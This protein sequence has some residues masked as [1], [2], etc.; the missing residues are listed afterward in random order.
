MKLRILKDLIGKAKASKAVGSSSCSFIFVV[1]DHALRV[2][3]SCMKLLNLMEEGIINTEKLELRRKGF[4][5]LHAIYFVAP[6]EENFRRI[7]K[8]FEEEAKPM[9]GVVHIFSTNAVDKSLMGILSNTKPLIQRLGTFV[10]MN[11]DLVCNEEKTFQ[12]GM[13]P[14]VP[15]LYSSFNSSQTMAICIADRLATI[16]PTFMEFHNIQIIWNKNQNMISATIA[17]RLASRLEGFVA[18]S[19][20]PSAP[21]T[22]FI[23]LDR[24]ADILTP[25]MHDYFYQGMLYDL[26]EVNGQIVDYP[27]EDEKGNKMT[28]K[29][30]LSEEDSIWV[31]YR[32][33][34]IAEVMTGVSDQFNDF[35]KNNSTSKLQRGELDNLNLS[36]MSEI[37]KTMPQYNEI[38]NRYTLHMFLIDKLF[39]EFNKQELIEIGE[40]EQSMSTGI[41]DKGASIVPSKLLPKMLSK[42]ASLGKM[43]GV[44]ARLRLAMIA[45]LCMPMSDSERKSLFEMVDIDDRMTIQKLKW[46]GFNIERKEKVQV[47]SRKFQASQAK[48]KLK[49]VSYS[50]CRSTPILETI[51]KH[52]QQTPNIDMN[53]FDLKNIP[54]GST[55]IQAKKTG[56]SSL[57]LKSSSSLNDPPRLVVFMVGGITYPELRLLRDLEKTDQIGGFDM[58]CGGTSLL[59]PA[60]FLEGVRKLANPI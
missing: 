51:V 10:E 41:D 50:L 23:I 47:A 27:A 53:T 7:A 11:L 40:F 52:V 38:L 33:R 29:A 60:D 35:L 34:H 3:S 12:L 44:N 39:E 59:R 46:F 31:E 15:E 14:C 18:K 45:C 24:S 20:S 30:V 48:N 37:I 36:S 19:G 17:N 21:P 22:R 16:I 49:S 6:T 28:K 13:P 55:F 1:D 42:V 32:D 8:D 56:A 58:Y 57:K 25:V 26:M 2:I 4:P 5:K 43:L 54:Q 9:Y